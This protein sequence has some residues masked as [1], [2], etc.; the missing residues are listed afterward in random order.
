MQE[1]HS[2][3]KIQPF[4]IFTPLKMATDGIPIPYAAQQSYRETYLTKA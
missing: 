4:F 3:P 2:T 1:Y